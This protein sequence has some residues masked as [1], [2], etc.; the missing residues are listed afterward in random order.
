MSVNAASVVEPLEV[1]VG[2]QLD[3]TAF[4]DSVHGNA[5]LAAAKPEWF[6]MHAGADLDPPVLPDPATVGGTKAWNFAALDT[7]VSA[8]YASGATPILNVRYAPRSMWTC[9]KYY[10]GQAGALKDA[11]F[12]AFAQYLARLVSY[13]NKGSMS[14]GAVTRVNPAGRTHRVTYWELWNEP[15]YSNETPCISKGWGPALTPAKYAAMWKTATAAMRAVDPNLRFIGPTVGYA[16]TGQSPDYVPT[17]LTQSVSPFAISVHGYGGTQTWTDRVLFYGDGSGYVGVPGVYNSYDHAAK[18][19]HKAGKSMPVFL[20]ETNLEYDWGDDPTKRPWTAF[21]AAFDAAVFGR[22]AKTAGTI[23]VPAVI[24]P[25]EFSAPGFELSELNPNTGK[26]LLN[27]WS[28]KG[29]RE[30]F[31]RGSSVIADSTSDSGLDVLAVKAAEGSV[32]VLIV[33][34]R[35][36]SANDIGANGP[37]KNVT[38]SVSGMPNVSGVKLW[39]LDNAVNAS[40]PVGQKLARGPAATIAFPGYGVAFLEFTP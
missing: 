13:Y 9:T 8:A 3:S 7:L 29:L 2:A 21:G 19:I 6:R 37:A 11:T 14:D 26:T 20:D 23:G 40:G 38:V 39:L 32:R 17:L 12:V 28:Y 25:Y 15:D 22:I 30:L 34:D 10:T 16:T 24:F 18:W 27:Y 5:A 33:N 4:F 36:V 1:S 35:A 31:V